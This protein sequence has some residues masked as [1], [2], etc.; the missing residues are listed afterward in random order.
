MKIQQFDYSADLTES[1]L[2]QYNK[3]VNIQKL[4]DYQQDF[5]N[6]NHVQFWQ[7]W[8][9]NVFNLQTAND[10]GLYVWSILLQLPI[11]LSPTPPVGQDVWGFGQFRKNFNHGNFAVTSDPYNLSTEEKRLVL[12]LR[13][14]Q[15]VTNGAV[16]PVNKFLNF[17]F[18]DFGECYIIDNL[19]MTITVIFG[20]IPRTE[21][22]DFIKRYDLIPRCDAVGIK[23]RYKYQDIWGFGQFRKNFNNGNFIGEL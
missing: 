14:F 1:I 11:Q 21:L 2:W 16:T 20:F 9:T 19:D 3:A 23:Y 15:L 18:Q 6:K 8:Y 13:Y 22:L 4:I 12:K 7:D 5:F 10:F 17:A